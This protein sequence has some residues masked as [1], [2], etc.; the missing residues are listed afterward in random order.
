MS[1]R[2]TSMGYA[3]SSQGNNCK[4][5]QKP[6]A[7]DKL[8]DIQE[9]IRR[10]RPRLEPF[11]R[12]VMIE[13]ADTST[14]WG[15]RWGFLSLNDLAHRCVMSRAKV[16]TTITELVELGLLSKRATYAKN[17]YRVNYEVIEAMAMGRKGADML[18]RRRAELEAGSPSVLVHD[19]DSPSPSG[20]PQ[21]STLSKDNTSKLAGPAAGASTPEDSQVKDTGQAR[22]D[23]ARRHWSKAGAKH[24]RITWESAWHRAPYSKFAGAGCSPW[25]RK[26][27]G[28]ASHLRKAWPGTTEEFHEFLNWVVFDWQNVMD[29]WGGSR[30]PSLPVVGYVLAARNKFFDLWNAAKVDGFTRDRT[31]DPAER[32]QA[33]GMDETEAIGRASGDIRPGEDIRNK[34]IQPA[35]KR[36]IY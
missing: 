24:Y 17:G 21:E 8:H 13:V 9:I 15:K 5:L 1:S 35:R 7:V 32:M 11:K 36:W 18:A 20:G 10:I 34:P 33:R 14:S 12:S 22:E 3:R 29:G 16:A 19:V 23:F 27:E 25:T 28:Q 2:P 30:K 6:S 4:R 31:N 26:A